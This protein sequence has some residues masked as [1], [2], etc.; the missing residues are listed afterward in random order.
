MKNLLATLLLLISTSVWA[1]DTISVSYSSTED[2]YLKSL[3]EFQGI[4][5]YKV[6][7]RGTMKDMPYKLY[8]VKCKEGK[9]EKEELAKDVPCKMDSVGNFNFFA[10]PENKDTLHLSCTYR[11]GLDLHI[12]VST[13]GHILMEVFPEKAYTINTPIPLIAYTAGE[14]VEFNI[15]GQKMKGSSY[16]NVRFSKTHP[17]EWYQKFKIKDYFYFELEF[18]PSSK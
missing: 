18:Q 12:P 16:C 6:T 9:I 15:N 17:S 8:L 3:M 14:A 5:G 11:V 2:T 1:Q 10:Q 13:E 7:V 4:Q